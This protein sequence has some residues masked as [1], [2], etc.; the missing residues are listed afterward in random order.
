[1]VYEFCISE[2]IDQSFSPQQTSSRNASRTLPEENT[3]IALHSRGR[4][5]IISLSFCDGATYRNAQ[6]SARPKK[7]GPRDS[8][9]AKH[10][11]NS[12][13]ILL[14][15]LFRFLQTST[16]LCLLVC[17]IRAAVF[18]VPPLLPILGAVQQERR[19]VFILGIIAFGNGDF[20]ALDGGPCLEHGLSRRRLECCFLKPGHPSVWGKSG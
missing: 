11:S 17:C 13:R 18:P 12:R 14:F 8:R 19:N 6:A 3:V 1:M 9:R 10:C 4:S 15:G 2:S 20:N 16:E 5:H 7:V